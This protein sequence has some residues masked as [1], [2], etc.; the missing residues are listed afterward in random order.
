VFLH[1]QIVNRGA[2][3]EDFVIE[4]RFVLIESL[5]SVIFKMQVR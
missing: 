3:Y 4:G 1:T 2:N 5:R